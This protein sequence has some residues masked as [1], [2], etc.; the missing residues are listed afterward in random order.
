[1]GKTQKRDRFLT[2]MGQQ[3]TVMVLSLG[4]QV[5][6]F[7]LAWICYEDKI[8]RSEYQPNIENGE[9]PLEGLSPGAKN[10]LFEPFFRFENDQF[11]KTGSG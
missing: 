3:D 11:T 10:A 4:L 9:A 8:A 6:A 7:V 5:V 1:M 2:G